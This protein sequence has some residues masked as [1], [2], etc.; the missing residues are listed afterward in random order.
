MVAMIFVRRW[1]TPVLYRQHTDA[2]DRK[3]IR[4]RAMGLSLR[5]RAICFQSMNSV[6]RKRAGWRRLAGIAAVAGGLGAA[7]IAHA[8]A[9]PA[10]VPAQTPA[11]APARV[12]PPGMEPVPLPESSPSDANGAQRGLEQND[13]KAQAPAQRVVPKVFTDDVRTDQQLS[14]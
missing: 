2:R 12:C 8:Q 3:R 7:G 6:G 10:D 14:P 9:Q 1:V 11:E 13:S 5:E 4:R